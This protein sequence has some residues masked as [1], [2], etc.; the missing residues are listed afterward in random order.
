MLWPGSTTKW[1]I[2]LFLWFAVVCGCL[3]WF[4]CISLVSLSIVPNYGGD[5][6]SFVV[7]CGRFAVVCLLVIPV[8]DAACR[9]G[10]ARGSASVSAFTSR[11][12]TTNLEPNPNREHGKNIGF[13]TSCH[14]LLSRSTPLD[15]CLCQTHENFISLTNALLP[16]YNRQWSVENAVCRFEELNQCVTCKDG[17]KFKEALR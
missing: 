15:T 11:P 17:T 10:Y 6:W 9:C 16:L 2:R 1:T 8:S 13:S 14:V 12:N 5:L 7:V 3:W 4:A